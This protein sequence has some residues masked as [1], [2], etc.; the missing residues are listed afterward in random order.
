MVTIFVGGQKVGNWAEAEQ[1]FAVA[2]RTQSVEFRDEIGRVIAT[3]VPG[4]EPIVP[5]D[6]SID[7][8]ELERRMAGPFVTF[9]E[10]KTRL[11]WE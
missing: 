11:G 7:Q 3:S 8:K 6:S 5:W 4:A 2:A 1:I 9:E 10:M